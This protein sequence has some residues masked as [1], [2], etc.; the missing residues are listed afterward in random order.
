[1]RHAAFYHW[2]I[3]EGREADFEAAWEEVTRDGKERCGAHGAI[4]HRCD[5]GTY[6]AY[7]LWPDKKS[8]EECWLGEPATTDAA[9]RLQDC[10]EREQAEVLMDEK[11][12]MLSK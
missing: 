1:M 6:A 3:K 12:D 10:V 11:R 2:K 4:L 7:A 9:K 8:R 5:D